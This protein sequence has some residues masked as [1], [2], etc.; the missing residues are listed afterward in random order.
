MAA[1]TSYT[2]RIVGHSNV[3][4]LRIRGFTVTDTAITGGADS[5]LAKLLPGGKATVTR[6]KKLGIR[7]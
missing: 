4:R 2:R 5:L 1:V 3:A 6:L 7:A